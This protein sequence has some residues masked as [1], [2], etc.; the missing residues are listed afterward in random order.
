MRKSILQF[1]V[2]SASLFN[3]A[4]LSAQAQVVINNTQNAAISGNNN[5]ITQ[6]INQTIIYRSKNSSNRSSFKKD[7]RDKEDRDNRKDWGHG[8]KHHNKGSH[9][10]RDD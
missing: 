1:S 4:P 10:E 5:Q 9:G 8:R 2:L 6:V 3:L 7:D